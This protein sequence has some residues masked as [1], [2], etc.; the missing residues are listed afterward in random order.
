MK[1]GG[2][3]REE[4]LVRRGRLLLGLL[5]DRGRSRGLSGGVSILSL[6]VLHLLSISGERGLLD[7]ITS[8]LTSSV[9][10][11]DEWL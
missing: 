9:N 8:I 7:A 3:A 4:A 6:K 10:L 2:E 1:D 11:S 5:H